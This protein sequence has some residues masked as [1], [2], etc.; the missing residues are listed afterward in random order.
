MPR[1]ARRQPGSRVRRAIRTEEPG[2]RGYGARQS[3]AAVASTTLKARRRTSRDAFEP[4]A[5]VV[6]SRL[7]AASQAQE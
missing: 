4:S 5:T 7:S 1:P 3:I 6:A 2:A